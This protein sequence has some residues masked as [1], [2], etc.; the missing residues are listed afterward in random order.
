ME[1]TK[2]SRVQMSQNIELQN[3]IVHGTEVEVRR[4]DAA[5]RLVGRILYRRELIHIHLLRNY[6]NSSRMLRSCSLDAVDASAHVEKLTGIVLPALLLTGLTGYHHG[7][8][9]RICAYGT[10]LE[11]MRGTE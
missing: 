11:S 9:T 2:N 3:G 7:V 4:N 1:H 10:R 5:R 8:L 6:D